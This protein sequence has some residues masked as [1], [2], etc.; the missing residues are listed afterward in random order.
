M[1]AKH[2]IQTYIDKLS[3]GIWGELCQDKPKLGAPFYFR[4]FAQE[5]LETQTTV[6]TT[7]EPEDKWKILFHIHTFNLDYIFNQ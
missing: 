4:D 6:F 3:N 7:A 2:S 1:Q 5:M